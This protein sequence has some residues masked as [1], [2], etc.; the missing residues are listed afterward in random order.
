MLPNPPHRLVIAATILICDLCRMPWRA[1]NCIEDLE[2][3]HYVQSETRI[4][5]VIWAPK[6]RMFMRS[7]GFLMDDG[8]ATFVI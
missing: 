1:V 6:K 3:A 8:V 5:R 4:G 2:G 7:V